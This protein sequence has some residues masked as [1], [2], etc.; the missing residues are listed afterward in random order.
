[1]LVPRKNLIGFNKTLLCLVFLSL[2]F[3]FLYLYYVESNF[4]TVN[5]VEILTDKSEYKLNDVVVLSIT[6]TV[7]QSSMLVVQ[8]PSGEVY[9]KH[10]VS[11]PNNVVPNQFKLEGYFFSVC[12]CTAKGTWSIKHVDYSGKELSATAFVVSD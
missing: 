11:Y 12:D 10:L 8:T 7:D 3:L 9:S 1:M 5:T 2:A 4:A 6:N